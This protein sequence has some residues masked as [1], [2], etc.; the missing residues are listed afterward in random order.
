VSGPTPQPPTIG[1]YSGILLHNI[2]EKGYTIVGL[3]NPSSVEQ[4]RLVEELQD[5]VLRGAARR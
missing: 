5:V 3:S 2:K 1:G 4:T